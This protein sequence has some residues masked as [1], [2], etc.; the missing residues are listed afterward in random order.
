M[1]ITRLY[2]SA[3]Q[4]A[5]LRV[6]VCASCTLVT[7][8][9]ASADTYPRQAGVDALHYVFRLTISDDS[10]EIAGESTATLRFTAAG[11]KEVA[12]DLI[13][14]TGD[15]G[16]SVSAVVCGGKPAQF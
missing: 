13:K 16:M 15:K 1:S 7:T 3:M 4:K 8:G 9:G 14:S 11:V 5:W 10:N 12:L 6:G 2:F